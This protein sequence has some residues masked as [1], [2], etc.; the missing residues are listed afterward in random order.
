MVRHPG[1]DVHIQVREAFG[2]GELDEVGLDAPGD[3]LERLAEAVN[4]AADMK[5]G[6]FLSQTLSGG[7]RSGC[8][9]PRGQATK[10]QNGCPAGSAKT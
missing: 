5:S 7:V 6:L 10:M 3:L 2:L 4:Q 1:N 8:I 9:G